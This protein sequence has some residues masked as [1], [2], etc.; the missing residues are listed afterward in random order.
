MRI[1]VFAGFLLPIQGAVIGQEVAPSQLLASLV[2][3]DAPTYAGG[4]TVDHRALADRISQSIASRFGDDRDCG[5]PYPGN[6]IGIPQ[7]PERL[8]SLDSVDPDLA[9]LIRALD[10]PSQEVRDVAAY[11]IGL[12]GPVAGEAAPFLEAKYADDSL[13]GGWFGVALERVT[14]DPVEDPE[15]YRTVP[16]AY[17]DARDDESSDAVIARLYLDENVEYPPWL[18]GYSRDAEDLLRQIVESPAL[19]A[20]KHM[21]ALCLLVRRGPDPLRSVPSDTLLQLADSED[22]DLRDCA[23]RALF[24]L[25]HERGIPLFASGVREDDWA[26]HWDQELCE[27]GSGAIAAEDGMAELATTSNWPR[28]AN[29]AVDVLGCIRSSKYVP[30]LIDMLA[31]TDWTRAEHAALALGAIGQTSDEVIDA[32]R[33]LSDSHWSE[34]VRQAG[35]EALVALGVEQPSQKA[36]VDNDQIIIIGGSPPVDHGLPWCDDSG[37]YSLD[38]VEWF[39]IDWIESTLQ[40]V[41]EGFP[42]TAVWLQEIGTQAFL[43]VSDGWLFGSNGFESEG[44]FAHVADDGTITEWEKNWG[45]VPWGDASIENIVHVSGRYFAFGYEILKV[46]EGGVLFEIEQGSDGRWFTER[47]TVLP[48]GPRW[49]AVSPGG[50]L[51]LSDGPNSYAVIDRRVV[52]LMCESVFEGDYFDRR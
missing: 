4:L 21:E 43:R 37:R 11:T 6:V 41:P 28:V 19:S 29:K 5:R 16:E 30:L 31:G 46:D 8:P 1:G 44:V 9:F 45:V 32:L 15:Q 34:R 18:L 38:G 39:E 42:E 27:L 50:D 20:R 25:D 52:P 49:H 36:E 24:L 40:D 14:C 35:M 7:I 10:S 13:M 47:T 33:M 12:L 26:G 23:T 2:E 51:L 22:L 17:F 48:S 3:L